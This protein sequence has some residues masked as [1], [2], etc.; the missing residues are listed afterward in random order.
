MVSVAVCYSTLPANLPVFGWKIVSF[1]KQK[2][3]L[4]PHNKTFQKQLFRIQL[5]PTRNSGCPTST[6]VFN[7]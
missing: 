4:L 3:P 1:K 6:V 2:P 5:L 7:S